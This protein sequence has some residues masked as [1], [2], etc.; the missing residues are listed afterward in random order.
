MARRKMSIRKHALRMTVLAPLLCAGAS[1]SVSAVSDV[2]LDDQGDRRGTNASAPSN[3]SE[4]TMT[5]TQV[6]IPPSSPPVAPERTLS[7]NPLWAMPLK[8][9][10]VT[11]ER[12]IFVPSRRPPAP[13][14][15]ASVTPVAVAVPKPKEPERPPL[16]LVGTISS[17]EERFGIFIDSSTKAVVRLKVGEDFQ[18]WALRAVQGREVALEKNKAVV[19]L[20]LPQPGLSQ[21]AIAVRQ[22]VWQPGA[23]DDGKLLPV[24]SQSQGRRERRRE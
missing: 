19:V 14:A 7:A 18:G 9:F 20:A 6:T 16:S 23:S 5:V 10:S 17:D 13:V 1:V 24:A 21:P 15:T 4:P 11:R 12:P 8:Q 22:E 3:W 2:A